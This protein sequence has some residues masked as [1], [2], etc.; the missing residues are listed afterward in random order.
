MSDSFLAVGLDVG[1]TKIAGGIV[2]LPSGAIL[3]KDVIMTLPQR[4]GDAVLSDALAFARR[5]VAE[6]VG[7]GTN[8]R[9]I[10]IGVAELIDPNGNIINDIPDRS[11]CG[12]VFELTLRAGRIAPRRRCESGESR[13]YPVTGR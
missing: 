1:G 10:G 8:V 4:G 7:K 13:G 2:G 11:A 3:S 5:L 12:T 6:A 9:G